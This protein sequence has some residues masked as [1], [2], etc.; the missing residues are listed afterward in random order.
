M[1]NNSW[2]EEALT[3]ANRPYI[4][5]VFLD[6]TT[7]GDLIYVAT[8]P[9]L[10]GCCA[11]GFTVEEAEAILAEVRIDYVTHRLANGLP[12]PEPGPVKASAGL[13]AENG[14]TAPELGQ[15]REELSEPH[16]LVI[17]TA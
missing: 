7:E 15:V 13:Q 2:H 3:I 8:N 17:E 9:D 1:S 4:R 12:I 14:D 5:F 16:L 10:P 6:E 11:Q